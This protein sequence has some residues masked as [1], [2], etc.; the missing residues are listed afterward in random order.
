MTSVSTTNDLDVWRGLPALQQPQWDDPAEVRAVVEELA[1]LPP[2]VFAGECDQ[3]RARLGDVARGEAFVLQ[4]GDCAETFAGSNADAV[5][6][7]LKTLLQMAVV[8]TYAAS[9]PVV[10]MGRMAGQF[11]KPRSKPMEARDGVELPAYRGDMVNGLEFTPEARRNDP[12][13]LLRAYHASAVTLN[14]CRAFTKGGYA[15]LRQVHRWNQDFVAQSPAGRRYERLAGEIDRALTFMKACGANPDEFHGVE[16]Y[17]S[18]EA[19][20]L[21]YERALTRVDSLS[22]LPYDV[23]AHFLWI[24]ERTR[25]LDG[26]HVD[27]LSRIRNPIGVK[28]GPT[29]SPDDALALIEKLNPEGEPGRLTF[30]TRM[31]AGKIRDALPPLIEKVR[32]SG[33]PVAWICDPMHGN[34]FEAPSGHKTRRVDDVLDE[35]AGFFEVHRAL[36]THP[37]GIHIEFTGDDVTECVGGGHPIVEGDLHQRYETACDPRL[38]RGQ[39]LDLA[40]MV[41]ELYRKS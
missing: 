21:E 7:K 16:F 35:V 29:T 24:G 23:S 8:L 31:G 17:S 36:G 26:A 34:T 25:Q 14:L 38:N 10:K 22:G 27:F 12:R 13:R 33:A 11:A 39:S 28:L 5:R 9:V 41:A 4:G 32:Q 2:L 37:G 18:H 30:V 3:L 15:D 6:N 1:Q 19:L 40:F 20:L